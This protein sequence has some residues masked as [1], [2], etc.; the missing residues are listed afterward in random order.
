MQEDNILLDC[1][2]NFEINSK[3]WVNKL[4]IDPSIYAKC[5]CLNMDMAIIDGRDEILKFIGADGIIK[6]SCCHN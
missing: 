5:G 2:Y 4:Y 1:L 6:D 3:E